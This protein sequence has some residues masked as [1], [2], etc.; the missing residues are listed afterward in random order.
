MQSEFIIGFGAQQH[1]GAWG[2]TGAPDAGCWCHP[3]VLDVHASPC[4]PCRARPLACVCPAAPSCMHSGVILEFCDGIFSLC[5]HKQ[6]Y[7]NG[8]FCSVIENAQG[9]GGRG[10]GRQAPAMT[11]PCLPRWGTRTP[12]LKNI[13]SPKIRIC[14]WS[15]RQRFTHAAPAPAGSAAGQ[16]NSVDADSAMARDRHPPS[17]TGLHPHAARTFSA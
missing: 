10:L 17:A 4:G 3:A 11:R 2:G 8:T 9:H 1:T 13:N 7:K 14:L 6:K 15:S 16:R 12:P 5:L